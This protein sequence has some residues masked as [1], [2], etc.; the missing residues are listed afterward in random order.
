MQKYLRKIKKK[1]GN[2]LSWNFITKIGRLLYVLENKIKS[3]LSTLSQ[4]IILLWKDSTKL[5]I[6]SSEIWMPL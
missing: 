6:V 2:K 4:Y 1:I 3:T 5:N